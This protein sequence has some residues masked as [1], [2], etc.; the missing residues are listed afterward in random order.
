[1]VAGEWC[2]VKDEHLYIGG[3]GKE[4]TTPY[5]NVI[6]FNPMFVKRVSPTGEVEH[7]DW[8]DNY[9]ALRKK[10]G[11]EFPGYMI[12]EAVSWSEHRGRTIQ[13]NSVEHENMNFPFMLPFA[14]LLACTH[15]GFH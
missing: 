5:G 1:M 10:A 11:I 15:R 12:H 14:I 7:L 2:A 3:L 6:N 8:H 13:W 9:L 4:W